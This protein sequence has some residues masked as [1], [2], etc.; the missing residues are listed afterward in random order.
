MELSH[1]F[2][3]LLLAGLG[4]LVLMTAWLPML[5]RK[6]PLSLPILCVAAGAALFALPP[7][8]P[9]A[10]HPLRSPV[11]VER[12]SELVVIVSLMGSGL[13]IDRMIGMRRPRQL[14]REHKRILFREGWFPYS[15]FRRLS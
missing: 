12:L 13:K 6:A 11:V 10:I 8:R 9:F 1:Q 14:D 4:V 7:L 3:V 5:L 2:Y 15:A